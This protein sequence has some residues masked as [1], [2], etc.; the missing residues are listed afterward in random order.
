MDRLANNANSSL[1]SLG[2]LDSTT[3]KKTKDQRPKIKDQR[4]KTKD[5]RPKSKDQRAK[6]KGVMR[7]ADLRWSRLHHCSIIS[8]DL[9]NGRLCVK[10]QGRQSKVNEGIQNWMH[11]HQ[12][13]R[14]VQEQ[15]RLHQIGTV[16]VS[17]GVLAGVNVRMKKQ[18]RSLLK[19]EK[20]KL[21]TRITPKLVNGF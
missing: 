10:D 12:L 8:V 13:Q 3:S 14:P 4:S 11:P 7:A 1:E 19:S 18:R 9:W 17:K 2:R 16:G 20:V 6:I 15:Q 21:Q 5:Q